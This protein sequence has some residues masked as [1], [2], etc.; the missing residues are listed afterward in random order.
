MSSGRGAER[1][2]RV[3]GWTSLVIQITMPQ[4]AN[5][6]VAFRIGISSNS[7]PVGVG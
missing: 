3:A 1:Q 4:R 7:S 6:Y 5:S 2:S